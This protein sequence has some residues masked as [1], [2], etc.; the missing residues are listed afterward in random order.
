MNLLSLRWLTWGTI[1]GSVASALQLAAGE[2][3]LHA[4]APRHGPGAQPPNAHA[5]PLPSEP[6][7]AG[8]RSPSKPASS[9]SQ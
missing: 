8:P 6:T 5:L 9:A 4:P 2:S 3:G 1:A 7:A